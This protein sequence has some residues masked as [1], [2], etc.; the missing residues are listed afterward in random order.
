ME[1]VKDSDEWTGPFLLPLSESRLLSVR[2]NHACSPISPNNLRPTLISY[3]FNYTL[4]RFTLVN[5]LQLCRLSNS[6]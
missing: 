1:R 5:Y 6:R 3:L 2:G 4:L